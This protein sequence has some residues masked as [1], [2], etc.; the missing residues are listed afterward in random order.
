M[1]NL[2]RFIKFIINS[3]KK[4]EFPDTVNFEITERCNLKCEHCYQIKNSSNQKDTF[5]DSE[6]EEK[7][8]YY[9]SIGV[10]NAII[11]G[12][13]PTLRLEV[14]KSAYG[15]FDFITIVSNGVSKISK[16]LNCRIFVSIDGPKKIHNTIR[17]GDVFQKTIDNIKGDK[18][19]I[20]TPTLS[21]TNYMYLNEFME[22]AKESKTFG[23]MFSTYTSHTHEKDN[24]LL[25]ETEL[26]YVVNELLRL[27]KKY[28]NILLMTPYMIKLLRKKKHIKKCFMKNHK[29]V[30]SFNSSLKEKKPCVIGNNVNCDTCGCIVPIIAH[31]LCVADIRAWILFGKIFPNK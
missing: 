11:T 22:I 4:T 29:K 15:I 2:M 8:K 26:D 6:W 20:I 19:V 24:L 14:I 17:G 25:S 18:R 1:N 5:T 23:I 30:I 7:F 31:A 27:R 21:K 9:H 3:Y 13:E 10:K 16:S 12:G 28:K